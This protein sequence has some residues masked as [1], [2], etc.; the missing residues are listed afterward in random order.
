MDFLYDSNRKTILGKE[1]VRNL[2]NDYVLCYDLEKIKCINTGKF[3]RL[4][5]IYI[6]EQSLY[7]TFNL[8]M[9]LEFPLPFETPSRSEFVDCR[10]AVQ[11]NHF[12]F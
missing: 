8:G 9:K 1:F 11:E 12:K 2:A 7:K 6:Q 5:N 3:V 4:T 10:Q